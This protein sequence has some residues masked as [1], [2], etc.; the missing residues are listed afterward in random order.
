MNYY[1]ITDLIN[2]SRFSTKVSGIQR[3]VLEG[4]KKIGE[5]GTVFFIS[6][7]SDNK[8]VVNNMA[9]NDLEDL[10]C[11]KD[12]FYYSDLSCATSRLTCYRYIDKYLSKFK[13]YRKPINLLLRL[14]LSK[15]NPLSSIVMKIIT[16]RALNKLDDC[17]GFDIKIIDKFDNNSN[18]LLF[19]GV[20]NFQNKYESIAEE[21]KKSDIS[22]IFMVYDMIPIVCEYVP[23]ELKEM[24]NKYIPFVLDSAD[25][26][27]VNSQ[28]CKLDLENYIDNSNSNRPEMK[29]V[30][31]AHYLPLSKKESSIVPLRT[32]KLSK[33]KY[34]LCAGSIESRKNHINLLILWRKF[35]NSA[36]YANEKLVIVGR[37]LW[38]T[39]SVM[40][41]LHSTG[42]LYGTVVL[43]ESAS[44]DEL[45]F[46]YENCRFTVFPSHYEGWGLPLG[47]SLR[48][49]KPCL[50]FNNSSLVEASY[51]MTTYVDYL[52]YSHFYDK[53]VALMQDDIFYVSEKNR[54]DITRL[55]SWDDFANEIYKVII[56]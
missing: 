48:Y 24:F 8:Y 47:E 4:L 12:F 14:A 41:L 9:F 49:E 45:N 40:H 22:L 35:I 13:W 50:H 25:K 34:V 53:F 33:E 6:P 31:L 19:G 29:V 28:S 11:F 23:D 17:N 56:Q 38:D 42:F 18:I 20:W 46:L 30:H 26:I 51:G 44:E 10:S 36:N 15:Y 16:N 52:D 54:I 27:I 1:D 21:A 7:F 55:R 39:E 3:V 43:I 37:L 2:H 32:R 5:D